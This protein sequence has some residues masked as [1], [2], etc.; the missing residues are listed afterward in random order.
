MA[1]EN[2]KQYKIPT[3]DTSDDELVTVANKWL[4]ESK[5]YHSELEKVWKE[6]EE[7]YK[8]KQTKI[9]KVP[10]DMSNAVQNHIFM[11][12]ETVVPI[13]TA[14][15]PQFLVEAPA[16]S[17]KAVEYSYAVQQVLTIHYETKDVR[18]AGE[19]LMR[20]MIVYRAGIWKVFWDTKIND[21]NLKSVR[22][23]RVYFPKVSTELPYL[24]E[25]IDITADDFVDV[26]GEGRFRKFLEHGGQEV[27]FDEEDWVKKVEGIWTIWEIWTSKMVF[28]K[29][30]GLIIEKRAN[31]TYDFTNKTKNHF[32]VPEIPYIIASVFRL[33]NSAIGETD[34]V[35]QTIP[36]QDVINVTNRLII[37]NAN[38]T[39]NSQWF[40]D[41]SVMTEEEARTKITNQCGLIVYGDGVANQ[42]LVR[43][44]SPPALPAYIPELKLMAERA[45]DNIFGTHSTTR[46]ERGAPETLGGRILL[47]QADLGRIDLIVREYERCVAKLGNWFA[48]LMKLNYIGKRTFGAYGEAGMKF[49]ELESSMMMSGMRIIIK[50]GTTLPT[51]ELSKRRE[52][53]ELWGMNALAPQTLYERMKFP[54]PAGEAQK[55]SVWLR[56]RMILE[57][58]A[59]AEVAAGTERGIKPLP[60]GG[61][62]VTRAT[63]EIT[64]GK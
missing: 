56:E 64:G 52:A 39:G 4:E 45:F 6:N 40:I 28:W 3:M 7:Y 27:N 25:K 47:K 48:Q 5:K 11:G 50:S 22:P 38:K 57:E 62:E 49:V 23:Q 30:G 53:L 41:S 55:L 34:L 59:K 10:S 63:E 29:H 37:N 61:G 26:F 42:T 18:T 8:G 17:D 1:E 54:D 15:P 13:I 46:G 32:E 35:Q 44:E 33:G 51:D 31:P 21:V 12:V 19:T 60:A 43:R 36:I 14:N 24:I 20:H 58:G 2:L 16:E 9:D